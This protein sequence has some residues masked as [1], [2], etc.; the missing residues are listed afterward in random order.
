[1]TDKIPGPKSEKIIERCTEASL[2][3]AAGMMRYIQVFVNGLQ[4]DI[5]CSPEAKLLDVIRNVLGLTGTK[6]VCEQG[7]CGS[8]S[9]IMNGKV[10]R[11]CQIPMKKVPDNAQLTTVEGIGTLDNPHPIQKAFAYKGAI[12]CGFCTPGM[13]V[14]AK[15][16]LDKNPHPTEEEIRHAFRGNLCRCTGYN[17]I[18][19]AVQLAAKLVSGEVKEEDIRV[20]TSDGTFGKYVPTPSSLAR[21]TG[22][23]QF[24]DDIAISADTLHL[25]VVRSPHHHANIKSIDT[26]EAERMPGVAGVLTAKDVPG[27]NRLSFASSPEYKMYQPNVCILYD[28]KVT[29]WGHPVA[30]VAAETSEQAAAAANVV[31]V[32]YDVLHRYKTPE[33]SLAEDAIPIIPEYNSN[34]TFISY[35]KK[36]G[37]MLNQGD[38]MIEGSFVTSR[39][40][41]LSLEPDNAIAFFDEEGRLTIMS[42]TIGPHAHIGSMSEALGIAPEKIRW[43]ENPS[44][45]QFGYKACITCEGFVALAAMKF[46]RPCKIVYDL[47]ETIL[48]TGKRT[49]CWAKAKLGANKD[50][51]LQSL[52]FYFTVD[53]GSSDMLGDL[54]VYKGLQS[55]GAPYNIPKVYAEGRLVTTNNNCAAPFRALGGLQ[56]ST[57]TGILIDMMA[58]KLGMDP[59]EF[60]YQNAWREGDIANWGAKL[61]CYPYPAMLEK[62][63]PL[64]QSAIAKARKESTVEKKRGVGIGAGIYGCNIDGFQDRSVAWV[65]LNPDNGVTVY[66]TWANPG[67]GGDIG[68]LT[69]ASKALNLPPEKIR[70]VS[71]DSTLCPNSG[72]SLASRQTTLT[73]NAIRLACEALKKAMEDSNC[74]TYQ[75]MVSKNLP[76]RYEGEKVCTKVVPIDRNGQGMPYETIQYNLQMAEVEVEIATGKVRVLKMTS[77][78]DVGVIHN[79]LAVEGQAEG[80][81]NMAAGFAL[82][83]AFEP[84]ETD[85]LRK[86]GIPNFKNSPE[87]ECLFNQTYRE[88]GTY[89]GCGVGEGVVVG[90]ASAVLNAIYNACGA[91]LFEVPATPGRVMAAMREKPQF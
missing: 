19:R 24:G 83:E 12:Q 54:L 79:P 61:D 62:L 44:G 4:R 72:P 75:D 20:D 35:L 17:S 22:A 15:D 18:I 50:G 73:G 42:R 80:G 84:G 36:G 32:E 11:S 33:D 25:K 9:V 45:G 31:K 68:M 87:T 70:T 14:A 7:Y 64:Y 60:R 53:S 1:V 3:D 46:R 67:E 57:V 41:H 2:T 38:S 71:R 66:A 10:V 21:A 37:D 51:Y 56:I 34:L 89:G 90:G 63:R 40:P 86:G 81:M 77:V 91:R 49:R 28:Q 55:L 30:I 48:T 13:I 85:T 47:A 88:D 52:V 59:L 78:T 74:K 8:C 27:T 6:R 82:W 69:I 23:L 5:V 29:E 58:E 26:S 39:T 76:L 43:I 16:L 65:E